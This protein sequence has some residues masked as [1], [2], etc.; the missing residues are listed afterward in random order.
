MGEKHVMYMET[1]LF[2]AVGIAS[3]QHE[4][5]ACTVCGRSVSVLKTDKQVLNIC[6][7]N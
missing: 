7:L 4:L 3:H 6:G 2:L 5:E 1:L